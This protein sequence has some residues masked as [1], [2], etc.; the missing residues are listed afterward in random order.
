V[1]GSNEAEINSKFLIQGVL[2]DSVITELKN[3]GFKAKIPYYENMAK[4]L[5]EGRE[6][7]N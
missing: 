4:G 1:I 2:R 6:W 5:D 3:R 7:S